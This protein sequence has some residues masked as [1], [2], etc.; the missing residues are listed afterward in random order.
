MTIESFTQEPA[1]ID[2]VEF[3]LDGV[4]EET[5]TSWPYSWTIEGKITGVHTIE[6][7]AY[8]SDYDTVSDEITA[9]LLII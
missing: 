3:L 2:H 1:N 8:T 7:V 5:V 4:L 6:V 9:T